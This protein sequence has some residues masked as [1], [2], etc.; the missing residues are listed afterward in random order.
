MIK[1]RIVKFTFGFA[2][3]A[4]K[5]ASVEG[6]TPIMSGLLEDFVN[7]AFDPLPLL[8]EAG[9]QECHLERIN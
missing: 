5:F 1:L 3:V 2:S 7:K 4:A 8:K 9:R 6:A